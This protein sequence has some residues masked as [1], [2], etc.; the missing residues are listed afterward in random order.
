MRFV[1]RIATL[2]VLLMGM[3][4]HASHAHVTSDQRFDIFSHSCMLVSE[5]PIGFAEARESGQWNCR[6]D[7]RA[8][9]APYVWLRTTLPDSVGN[10]LVLRGMAAP[11]E[12][13]TLIVEG[14]DGAVNRTV[15]NEAD[16][17]RHW[18]PGN[19]FA[20]P[21]PENVAPGATIYIELRQ[22]LSR[23]MATELSL[24][25][26]EKATRERLSRTF[27]YSLCAGMLILVALLSGVLS[28]LMR[29]VSAGLHAIF[30][31]GAAGYVL[32]ASSIVF[33]LAPDLPLWDRQAFSYA[34]LGIGV[35]M[36]A[37]ILYLHVDEGTL[38]RPQ[39]IGLAVGTFG[40]LVAA[41]ALPLSTWF[42]FNARTVFHLAF[43]PFIVVLFWIIGSALW[44]GERSIIG[45][46][47]AWSALIVLGI[48]RVLRG[49][50]F[51]FA[52]MWLDYLFFFGLAFQA[53]VMTVAIAYQTQTLRKDRDRERAVALSALETAMTDSLTRLPN[54]RDFDQFDWQRADFFG[55]VDLDR[56]KAINDTY[57]HDIGDQVLRV[58]ADALSPNDDTGIVRA[59]RLGG[60]EFA[61]A[62]Q[63]PSIEAAAI[64]FNRLRG[65]ASARVARDVPQITRP[66]TVSAG[67]VAL[68]PDPR[69]AFR[70]AD[71]ALYRAKTS[72]RDRLCY[73]TESGDLATMFPGTG[74]SQAA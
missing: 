44:R 53:L 58:M 26:A 34:L 7:F 60:E 8:A 50:D 62:M 6:P 69:K 56:F 52:P 61:I 63:A 31:L 30:S 20:A 27:F 65:E 45:F 14:A 11:V 57:G 17:R 40:S 51:Y 54:R 15:L 70:A 66:V 55:F 2:C 59:W 28:Y 49:A 46:A 67:L 13:L 36:V 47:L 39:K 19:Y 29:S 23:L 32:S 5:T 37:P 21:L 33:I 9:E 1:L 10:D 16:L 24:E 43:I 22:P 74:T 4:S 72:G 18:T 48:E 71:V 25:A 64:A 38:T 35:M 41:L 73:Q 68:A 12:R 3:W 42:D